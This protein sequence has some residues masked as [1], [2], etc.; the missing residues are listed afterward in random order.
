MKRA[1]WETGFLCQVNG[2]LVYILGAF[3]LIYKESSK[4]NKSRTVAS[5]FYPLVRDIDRMASSSSIRLN[6]GLPEKHIS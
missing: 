2:H 5:I 1:M 3:G 4:N 6:C